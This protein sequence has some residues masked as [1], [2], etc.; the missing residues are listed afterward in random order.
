MYTLCLGYQCYE[1]QPEPRRVTLQ[2]DK[3]GL[4]LRVSHLLQG[5]AVTVV[6]GEVQ[7]TVP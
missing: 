3:Q 5:S 6:V 1:R 7:G 4:L 2:S